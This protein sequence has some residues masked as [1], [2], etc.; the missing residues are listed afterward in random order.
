MNHNPSFLQWFGTN[1]AGLFLWGLLIEYYTDS[2]SSFSYSQF[3]WNQTL[4]AKICLKD[5]GQL[6]VPVFP[7]YLIPLDV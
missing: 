1:K 2:P 4:A 6:K 3:Q 5:E 7:P